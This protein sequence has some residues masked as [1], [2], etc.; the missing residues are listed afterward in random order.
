MPSTFRSLK[1]FYFSGF[2]VFFWGLL[3]L[4][5]PFIK[6]VLLLIAT[7]TIA[8]ILIGLFDAGATCNFTFYYLV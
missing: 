7:S 6:S 3:L 4:L 2:G 5:M 1:M 8:G